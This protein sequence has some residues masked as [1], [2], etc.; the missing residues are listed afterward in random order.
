MLSL[1]PTEATLSQFAVGKE[2]V[3]EMQPDFTNNNGESTLGKITSFS[4]S[5]ASDD[6]IQPAWP[7]GAAITA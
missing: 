6:E 1:E 5:I 7:E 2:Y 3:L 4:F